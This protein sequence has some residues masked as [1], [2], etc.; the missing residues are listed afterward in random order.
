MIEFQPNTRYKIL[1]PNGF[2]PFSGIRKTSKTEVVEIGI[3]NDKV[4]EASLDH[5][6]IINSIETL[7]KDLKVGDILST[8]IIVTRVLIKSGDFTLYDPTDVGSDH[9][10]IADGI[11]SHNCD[12]LTSGHT[13]IPVETLADWEARKDL[14]CDPVEKRGPS[15]EYWIW[16]YPDYSKNYAVIAD[17]S[18]G[19]GSDYSSFHIFDIEAREQVGEFKGKMDTTAFGRMLVSVATDFNKAL[20]VIENT[21]VGWSTVQVALDEGYTNLYYS[22]KNDPFLDENIQLRKNYD[23]KNKEDMV[24]GFTTSHKTRPVIVSKLEI[25]FQ[26]DNFIIRSARTLSELRVFL[27]INGRPEAQRGYNDDLVMPLATFFYLYDIVLRMRQ[28]GVELT[29]KALTHTKRVV[30]IPSRQGVDPWKVQTG[31]TKESLKWLL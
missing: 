14:I 18:R 15:G 6:F 17:V 19:D 31:K 28:M 1:T 4:I 21:G 9:L 20:L 2:Q 16:K 11:V 22:Y 3:S 29:K 26:L 25:A 13:V 7:A 30:Y 10:F 27:W 12:F 8:G 5:K 24:P 23:L